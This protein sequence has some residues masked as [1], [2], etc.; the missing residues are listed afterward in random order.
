LTVAGNVNSLIGCFEL[1]NAITVNKNGVAGGA[2]AI[3]D[4]STEI[5]ICAGDGISDIFDVDLD[6]NEGSS[7]W[8]ITDQNNLILDLSDGPPFD[9]EG[10]GGGVCFIRHLGFSGDLNGLEVGLNTNNI[11]G[12]FDLVALLPLR[13][14]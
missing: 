2:I 8:V 6:D 1:S 4:G 10:E 12:C 7:I 5:T 9:L 13:L 3:A 11:S 14:D